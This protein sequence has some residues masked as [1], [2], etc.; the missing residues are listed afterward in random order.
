[1]K[2]GLNQPNGFNTH[3]AKDSSKYIDNKSDSKSNFVSN[4]QTSNTEKTNLTHT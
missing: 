4:I 1:M 3:F 2:I